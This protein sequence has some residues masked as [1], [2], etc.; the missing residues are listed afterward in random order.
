MQPF[1]AY[2][3]DGADEWGEEPSHSASTESGSDG[4][5]AWP[6][7][8]LVWCHERC[9]K[10]E[11]KWKQTVIRDVAHD[12]GATLV[13]CRKA[14]KFAEWI[15][16]AGQ[17]PYGLLADWKEVKPCLE[18]AVWCPP[19]SHPAFVVIYDDMPKSRERAT[20][21]VWARH[22]PA[23]PMRILADVDLLK[24]CLNGLV[25]DST[26]LP[27]GLNLAPKGGRLPGQ[28]GVSCLPQYVSMDSCWPGARSQELKPPDAPSI[29]MPA[30]PGVPS[31]SPKD[32]LVNVPMQIGAVQQ[33]ATS[34]KSGL[35]T[36]ACG[37]EAAVE[38][39]EDKVHSEPVPL[40]TGGAAQG[41]ECKLM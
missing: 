8:T 39:V 37:D 15:A 36:D 5:G 35:A 17:S 24:F 32:Q 19:S 20:A 26:A 13:C 9:H 14:W 12:M 27:G 25:S 29:P 16:Q 23:V 38:E 41:M 1:R 10:V 7:W 33:Q 2:G 11:C 3:A 18:A 34:L 21:W 31:A 4:V 28:L 6:W 22:Y 30:L 40:L